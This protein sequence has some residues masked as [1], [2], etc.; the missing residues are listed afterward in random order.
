MYYAFACVDF[1]EL[2]YDLLK[3]CVAGELRADD[4]AAFFTDL[5]TNLVSRHDR[6]CVGVR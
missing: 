5:N 2:A 3:R 6:C 4:A 1:H